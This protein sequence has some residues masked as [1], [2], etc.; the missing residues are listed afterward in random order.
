MKKIFLILLFLFIMTNTVVFARINVPE[1]IKI[2]TKDGTVVEIELD[3]YLYGVVQSE[4]GV[5]YKADGMSA[6]EP[7]PLDALKAQAVVSRTYA[8]YNILKADEDAEY[9]VT[10]T[11]SHQVYRDDIDV[12]K[13][14]KKAVDETTGQI[15]TY[16]DEVAC[17]YFFSTSGGH[18]ESPENVW[19]SKIPYLKGVEDPYE[20]EV[21]NKT[22][23]ECELSQEDLRELFPNLGKIK[24][25]EI[26]DYSEN[27]RVTELKIIGSKGSTMLT[28]NGIRLEL[29]TTKVR[30]QWFEVEED[31]GDFIFTGRG[32]GHGIGMSQNGAIG[33]A[34]EGFTYDEILKWYYTDIEIHGFEKDDDY[35]V[36][37]NQEDYYIPEE[38]KPLLEALTNICTTNWLLNTIKK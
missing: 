8:V 16:D 30:S 20:I 10:T 25:I 15:V 37:N 29:G 24:E 33:M 22:T 34:I 21:A 13:N 18:T 12:N 35:E 38:T 7:I 28:K 3:T 4:M 27:D 11:T 9:H 32:Y 31:D 23:W 19:S 5:N 17:T 14:V 2:K 26:H 36:D 1:Y 6:S